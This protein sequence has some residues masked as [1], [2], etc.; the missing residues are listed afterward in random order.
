MQ[1]KVNPSGQQ[2]VKR[3]LILESAYK[4]F[5]H[6]GYSKTTMNDIASDLSF[7][8]ALLYYYFPD[9]SE[10]Y[11]AVTRKLAN[12]Y[13]I[14]LEE[15]INDF[16]D[17]KEAI[18][19][20]INVQHDF[21]VNNNIFFDFFRIKEQ[22]LPDGIWTIL[23]DIRQVEINLLSKIIKAEEEKGIICH[24]DDP[25]KVADTLLDALRGIRVSASGDKKILLFP[26]EEQLDNIHHKQLLL[27]DI[28]INGLTN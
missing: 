12:E 20:Q 11:T 4:R 10:L 3:E 13:F 25:V 1:N 19:F 28:F 9:K 16:N 24:V 8:K 14:T 21:L 6:Y 18:I 2:D 5:L 17:L 22:N 23:A 7:S 15:K 27:I 26:R